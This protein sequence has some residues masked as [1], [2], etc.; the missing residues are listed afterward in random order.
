MLE[1]WLA[2]LRAEDSFKTEADASEADPLRPSAAA[3]RLTCTPAVFLVLL[4]PAPPAPALHPP[5]RTDA[6]A[7]PPGRPRPQTPPQPE[8]CLPGRGPASSSGS[9]FA[10]VRLRTEGSWE[11]ALQGR[12]PGLPAPG[13]GQGRL[14]SP[15][16]S[17]APSYIARQGCCCRCPPGSLLPIFSSHSP[18]RVTAECRP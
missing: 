11:P 2:R 17:T 15:A 10:S 6:G 12:S 14:P 13:G 5:I 18:W 4:L 8:D 1:D 16:R 7:L 3:L 9:S